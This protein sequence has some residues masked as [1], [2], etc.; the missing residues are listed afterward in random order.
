MS[1]SNSLSPAQIAA[2]RAAF[3][4]IIPPDEY[5]G[6]VENGV[7]EYLTGQF[8]RDLASTA[9]LYQTG[10]AALDSEAGERYGKTFAQLDAAQQDELLTAV[11]SGDVQTEWVISPRRFFEMLVNHSAEGF[12]GDPGNGANLDKNSWQMIGFLDRR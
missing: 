11:E 7:E 3:S 1:L 6:A 2:L 12:Y 10:L 8:T 9:P 4:R 5:P